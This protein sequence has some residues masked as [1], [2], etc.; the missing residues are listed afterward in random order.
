MSLVGS[1]HFATGDQ[2]ILVEDHPF[3]SGLKRLTIV[4]V[5]SLDLPKITQAPKQDVA[6]LLHSYTKAVKIIHA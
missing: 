3:H 2:I 6:S 1:N 5:G 4:E